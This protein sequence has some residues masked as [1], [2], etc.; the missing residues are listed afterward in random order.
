MLRSASSSQKINMYCTVILLLSMPV[1]FDALV[2]FT[3]ACYS[4]MIGALAR[5]VVV[6]DDESDDEMYGRRSAEIFSTRTGCCSSQNECPSN[7]A[8]SDGGSPGLR[9]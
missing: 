4:S 5:A 7:E 2:V 1:L 9:C 6:L 3:T 8:D